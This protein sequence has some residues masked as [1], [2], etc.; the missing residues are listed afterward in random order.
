M[1]KIYFISTLLLSL[2]LLW[3]SI[4]MFGA[5]VM[6]DAFSRLGFP[7]YFRVQLG[8]AGVMAVVG[9][10]L[11]LNQTLKEWTYASLTIY[12][13][14]ALVA[15][16]AVGDG[17]AKIMVMISCGIVLF[18]SYASYRLVTKKTL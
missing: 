8:I 10:N 6:D 9:L 3:V 13:V 5:E 15:H 12:W 2:L 16:L 1:K 17:V 7:S 11:K 18:V 14:S 4:L